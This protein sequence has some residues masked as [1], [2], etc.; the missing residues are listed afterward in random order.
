M[1]KFFLLQTTIVVD[2]IH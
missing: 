2:C 1:A